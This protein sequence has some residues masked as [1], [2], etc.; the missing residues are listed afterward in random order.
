ML[1]QMDELH[2]GKSILGAQLAAACS[3]EQC[4]G[5]QNADETG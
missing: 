3:D 1:W 4:K 2:D 5:L